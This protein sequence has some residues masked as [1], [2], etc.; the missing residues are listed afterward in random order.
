MYD[1]KLLV[2]IIIFGLIAITF[3]L[4]AAISIFGLLDYEDLG[5]CSEEDCT[6]D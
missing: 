4:L 1:L 6:D 3:T 5:S 2:V